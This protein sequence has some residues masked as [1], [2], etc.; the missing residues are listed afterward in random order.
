[1]LA[2]GFLSPFAGGAE[3]IPTPVGSTQKYYPVEEVDDGELPF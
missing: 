2:D 1:M 3:P